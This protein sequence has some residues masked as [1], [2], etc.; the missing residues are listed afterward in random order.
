MLEYAFI[1]LI[2]SLCSFHLHHYLLPSFF[3]KIYSLRGYVLFKVYANSEEITPPEASTE[4]RLPQTPPLE[5][6]QPK[7]TCDLCNVTT[8]SESTLNAHLQ[9]RNHKSN[10]DSL[11]SSLLDAEDAASASWVT[12]EIETSQWFFSSIWENEK[13]SLYLAL[14]YFVAFRS[15]CQVLHLN[16]HCSALLFCY[17]LIW[18]T[19]E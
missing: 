17:S 7:W 15:F 6:T 14:M 1:H 3:C 13:Q 8:T 5:K 16:D 2:Q 18:K 19:A 12:F 9:G 4:N 10:L 11:K